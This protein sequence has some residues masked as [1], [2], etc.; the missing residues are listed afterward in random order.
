[1]A[2]KEFLKGPCFHIWLL[3]FIGLIATVGFMLSGSEPTRQIG[4]GLDRP[5]EWLEHVY[6]WKSNPSL[7]I[8]PFVFGAVELLALGFILDALKTPRW[9]YC[10]GL[11]LYAYF[12]WG[13]AWG[14]V[15][16][17]VVQVTV[18]WSGVLAVLAVLRWRIREA[19]D[20]S[21]PGKVPASM[22]GSKA[23]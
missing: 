11:P 21:K 2:P 9:I 19:F 16:F 4:W 14:Q 22:M 23:Q 6:R 5:G 12:G 17:T 3:P 15:C 10:L 13:K 20:F 18:L 1:M 8:M 7:L